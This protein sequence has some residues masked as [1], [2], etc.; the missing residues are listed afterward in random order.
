[1]TTYPIAPNLSVGDITDCERARVLD[2]NV[3]PAIV[4]VDGAC[5][6]MEGN[7]DL[8]AHI[9]DN[10]EGAAMLEPMLPRTFAFIDRHRPGRHVIVHCTAG[11][12][13]SPTVVLLYLIHIGEMDE[14][15]FHRKHAAYTPNPAL[16]QLITRAENEAWDIDHM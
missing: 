9:T 14:N 3:R 2:P 7:L 12:S 15:E 6:V 16:Q 11:I 8:T 13:R 5:C 4:H 1:M 10:D